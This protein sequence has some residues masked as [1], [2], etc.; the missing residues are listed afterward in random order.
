MIGRIIANNLEKAA[1]VQVLQSL[2]DP[3]I[4]LFMPAVETGG[5]T[6]IGQ[7]ENVETFL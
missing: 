1:R 7:V 5:F 2:R 4:H 6:L 3:L